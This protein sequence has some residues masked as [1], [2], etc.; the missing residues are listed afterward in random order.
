MQKLQ[1][2]RTAP[3]RVNLL[4][5]YKKEKNAKLRERY[6]ALIFM[7]DFNSCVKVAELLQKSSRTIQLWVNLFNKGGIKALIPHSPPGRP[8]RLT[9]EEKDLKEIQ[10][11]IDDFISW[12][13]NLVHSSVK[14][15]PVN[16]IKPTGLKNYPL[17]L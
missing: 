3:N 14:N 8:S 6:L 16:I 13:P 5:L 15:K 7:Q 12:I 10:Q 4:R 11:A 17:S 1:I 9:R 2:M